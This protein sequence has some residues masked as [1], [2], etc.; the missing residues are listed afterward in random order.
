MH[1]IEPTTF[2]WKD[3]EFRRAGMDYVQHV[4][5]MKHTSWEIFLKNKGAARV[6]LVETDGATPLWDF[7]FQPNDILLLG[8]E[9]AGVPRAVY[10]ACDTNVFIPMKEGVRSLNVVTAGAIA[11]GEAVRQSR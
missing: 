6:V 10:D 2:A 1:V 3:S 5:L 4:N 9:S 11:L 7:Q 8:R